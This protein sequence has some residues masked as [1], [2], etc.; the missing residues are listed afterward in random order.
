MKRI[1]L[2]CAL[3]LCACSLHAQY[4]TT[5]NINGS[6]AT[7]FATPP[8]ASPWCLVVQLPANTISVGITLSGTWSATVQFEGTSVST[9]NDAS[10][11]SL[12]TPSSTTNTTFTFVP[13]GLVA[14]RARISAFTSGVVTVAITTITGTVAGSG[15]GGSLP[16]GVTG[17]TNPLL[18]LQQNANGA[19]TLNGARFTDTTP[20]GTFLNFMNAAKNATLFS[21]DVLGNV[22]GNSFQTNGAGAGY[23]QCSNGNGTLPTLVAGAA[24]IS[25]P[26]GAITNYTML[27]P[28]AAG[29]GCLSYANAANILTPSFVACGGAAGVV[30]VPGTTAANTIAPTVDVVG[31]TV[32]QTTAGAPASDVFDVCTNSAGSCGTKQ[33]YIQPNGNVH[34]NASAFLID[35]VGVESI[36]G[37]T[38]KLDNNNFGD[39]VT[40]NETAARTHNLTDSSGTL[41]TSLCANVTPVTTSGGNVTT[42]QNGMACSITAKSL[43]LAGR[44]IRIHVKSVYTTAAGN[45]AAIT[46]KIKLCSVSGCGSGNVTTLA[47]LLSTAQVGTITN[48]PIIV[49]LTATTQTAGVASRF[50]A[51][52]NMIID[53][54]ATSVSA[55]LNFPDQ[56]ITTLAGSPSDLDITA[57]IFIQSTVAFSISNA[58]DVMTDRQM[59]VE[60]IN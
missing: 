17:G 25:C 33:F 31:L 50:E 48:N 23:F 52:G 59:T 44:T 35:G 8:Q 22:T 9:T 56:N 54:A 58:S 37:A 14:V 6:G 10:Y 12:S 24:Q 36:G 1:L 16:A 41:E 20:T 55:A 2:L 53:L 11:V 7:C 43:N 19:D 28:T 21:V 49:D 30:L 40:A 39:T 29:T 4:T 38:I 46:R 26:S 60:I 34:V 18:F 42:D 51:S 57:Q 15:G 5:L 32:L 27:L 45:L 47:T 13:V 3:M